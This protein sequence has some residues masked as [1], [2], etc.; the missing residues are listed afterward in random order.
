MDTLYILFKRIF[1]ISNTVFTRHSQTPFWQL[2]CLVNK[3]NLAQ[4]LFF[5]LE[6]IVHILIALLIDYQLRL[7]HNRP[8]STLFKEA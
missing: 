8:I 6:I 1:K 2:W 3:L 7:V 5:V 4:V